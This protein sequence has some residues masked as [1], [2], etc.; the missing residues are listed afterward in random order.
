MD[1]LIIHY[2]KEV[3]SKDLMV[4]I[5]LALCGWIFRWEQKL[6]QLVIL[7]S[8]GVEKPP[9]YSEIENLLSTIIY[10]IIRACQGDR[11]VHALSPL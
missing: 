4:S 9:Y 6:C 8:G 10:S 5:Y 1:V 3:R 11:R 7:H 2:L